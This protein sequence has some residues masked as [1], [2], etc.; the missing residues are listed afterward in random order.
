MTANY[1]TSRWKTNR[2]RYVRNNKKDKARWSSEI[3]IF[4]QKLNFIAPNEDGKKSADEHDYHENFLDRTATLKGS[5]VVLDFDEKYL[6]LPEMFVPEDL[7]SFEEQ[8]ATQTIDL[9]QDKTNSFAWEKRV[10]SHAELQ[11]ELEL[12]QKIN[13]CKDI[14]TTV[15][16]LGPK[17]DTDFR[18]NRKK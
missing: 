17:A 8:F 16:A 9:T 13:A 3:K 7:N 10:K 4:M 5:N 18:P 2:D 14:A 6:S 15:G 12:Q 1:L 11:E